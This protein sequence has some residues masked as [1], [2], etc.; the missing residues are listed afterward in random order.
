MK[1]V[2]RVL[3]LIMLAAMR[4]A[5]LEPA[6]VARAD[7]TPA[8]QTVA[9]PGTLQS[10][11]GC[12]GDWRPDCDK[13]FLTYDAEDDVWQGAFAVQPDDDQ[14]EKGPRYKAAL[15]GSWDENY[16][17]HAARSG[18]D[19]PLGVSQSTLV[20]FYYDHKTHWV[21]D[22]FN[23]PIVVAVGDFQS[24]LGCK[25]DDDPGC[26]RSW[27]QDPEGDGTY[28][29]VTRQLPPGTY[30]V[31]LGINEAMAALTG[32]LRQ[33]TVEEDGDEIYFGY[34]PAAKEFL[35]STE[36]AP[37]GNLGKARAHW[38]ARDTIVWNVVGSPKYTYEL[39]YSPDAA[40]KQEADS[41]AGG[42]AL[43]LTF[44]VAGPGKD[45][46][47]KFPHLTGHTTLKLDAADAAKAPD[48]L[49]GQMAVVV[50]DAKGK[51]IDAT[52]VQIPGV[53]DDL[54]TY[55]GPLG[56]TYAGAVLTL[57]V[58]APTAQSVTLHLFD[59][60]T[61]TSGAAI[62]MTWDAATGAWSATGAADWTN[63]FYLYEVEVY[64]PSTG[65][66]E[67]NLVTDPY[68]LSLSTNSTRSQIVNLA[69]AGLKPPGWDQLSKPALAAPEDSVIYELHVRD[70][71]LHDKTVPAGERG[72]FT[73]FT[74]QNSDGMKHL[75]A[76]AAAGLTHI[77]LLPAF[78]FASV[79]EDK[80]KWKSVDETLL[81]T[82]P[83]DSD[84]QQAAVNA[85]KE[86]DG[87]NWGYDP[88][89]FTA[90]E[91]SYATDPDG[92]A[93]I[94]EFRAMVQALNTSGLRVVMDVVYNHTH[95]S[96]Q[97]EQSVLDKIVP[98][99]YQRLNGEGAVETST[100]CQNTAAEHAMMEKLMIDSLVTWATAYKVDGFRFDLM[101]HHML[102]NMVN[103]R[104]ALDA[105]TP[106]KD[107]VDG[108][109]ITIY[110]EGWNFGEVADNARGR[111]ATQLNIGGT[112]IGAFNDRL[113][114]AARGGGPFSG[115]QA[116]GVLTGLF[117]D[118]NDADQGAPA[119]QR[120]QLLEYMDWIRVGLAGGL[121]DYEL[122]NAAGD[123]VRSADVLYN[124]QPA[125]YTL[126]PQE[127][128][129]YVSAHDN[130]TLFDA[131][132]LKAP[133]GAAL[134]DRVR[135]HDLGVSLVM[136]S[137][138]VPFF[139]AGDDLLRSKS[140]D[141]NSYNSGDWFN[142]LDFTYASN[143]WG[144]GLPPDNDD[145]WL[146]MRPLLADPALKPAQADI[147]D[148]AAHFREMLT[149]RRSSRL[150]RL[151]TAAEV[152]A[153]LTFLNTGPDQIPGL[154]VMVL[155]NT[156]AQ[157][158]SDPYGR[159]VVVFNA[160]KSTRTFPD[161]SFRNAA[162]E[163]HPVQASS[164]DPVVKTAGFDKTAGA[165]TVPARTTA[166]FVT[167]APPSASGWVWLLLGGALAG[168]AGLWAARRRK[169]AK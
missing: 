12:S 102:T 152:A 150:F 54:Y 137:Q 131:I 36:G 68:S 143:N 91:G 70:F 94:L 19:I 149:I 81:R 63:K 80:S 145:R 2:S 85:I 138:G 164:N 163:L 8:P 44:T 118:P 97:A 130:E 139:H 103:V 17:A 168:V 64:V 101:G 30:T 77:H 25:K 45:V 156:G 122:V 136:L 9:I 50:R 90:P 146:V 79:D 1:S 100:C 110:G 151:Q 42:A 69:D 29:F 144:V 161:A 5:A 51:L 60:A 93:R 92:S 6:P 128:I 76:L 83:P 154:I 47:A 133:A 117:D 98:G 26:L 75:T 95:A 65:K 167:P 31:E 33:F 105:L 158:L 159:I 46:L 160:T 153:H 166:V 129:V 86:N 16:G 43:L 24:K 38:V 3:S 58:W 84:Q 120:A 37:S 165:F 121:R 104:Q 148:A 89:H 74:E 134:A 135:M 126:D 88:Y 147:L 132:Q 55:A 52:G 34:T 10:E 4:L 49:R 41:L 162:F 14:D 40:L 67:R 96:G 112:G 56:V 66:V 62:P 59:D 32:D 140:L 28:S 27:L 169:A 142:A 99:Y 119:A 18:A 78:D 115:L 114:D 107:G 57:R 125:G 61:A 35:V 20:K 113:R 39:H 53:L 82:Y 15:N 141:R 155:D 48:I 21:T 23:T 124:G 116:Q 127:N 11:L 71:S 87:F 106:A 7:D 109:A 22:N 72:T 157:R 111:N 13:T 123:L 108:K 73:A